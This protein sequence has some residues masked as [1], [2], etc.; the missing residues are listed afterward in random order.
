MKKYV[1][2]KR[3][4][5]SILL[6]CLIIAFVVTGTVVMLSPRVSAEGEVLASRGWRNLRYFTAL[7]NEFCG[8]VS[9]LWIVQNIRGKRFSP[10]LKLMAVAS[11]GLTFAVVAFFLAPM[12]P[13]MN[14][15]QGGNFWFHLIVPVTAMIEFL[16]LDTEKLP[17]KKNLVAAL[18]S[19][20]YGLGYLI[21]VLINGKG[22][23][24]N[25]ND[26]YGFLSWGYPMGFL[27]FGFIFLMNWG[28][29]CLMQLLNKWGQRIV[30][31]IAIGWR[32]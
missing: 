13:H 29:A 14:L 8:I 10:L 18:P 2:S 20:V 4:I 11:V 26:W 17:V 22:E 30:A 3:Q 31:L 9:I 23:W 27:I 1:I 28:I 32:G 12:N 15:Y 21:N 6:N 5:I 7:S 16:I 19:A 25:T 24:P